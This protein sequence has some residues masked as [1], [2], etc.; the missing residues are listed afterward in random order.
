MTAWPDLAAAAEAT[1]LTDVAD[2]A[3][4]MVDALPGGERQRARLAMLVA[5]DA[6]S[7]LLDELVAALDIAHPIGVTTP[8]ALRTIHGSAVGIISHPTSGLPLSYVAGTLPC[9]SGRAGE[10]SILPFR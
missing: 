1:A 4:R 10:P 8:A 9:R 7:L 3:G 5:R 2:C 6:G